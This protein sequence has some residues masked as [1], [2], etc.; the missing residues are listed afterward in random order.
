MVRGE[1]VARPLQQLSDPSRTFCLGLSGGFSSPGGLE[2]LREPGRIGVDALNVMQ[3]LDRVRE[4]PRVHSRLREIQLARNPAFLLLSSP[5]FFLEV[6]TS[7][8]L[9]FPRTAL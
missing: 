7:P 3:H 8:C 2:N 4:L 5:I 9:V 1:V 6:M